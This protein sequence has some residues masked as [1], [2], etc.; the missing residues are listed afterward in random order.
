MLT[1]IGLKEAVEFAAKTEELAQKAY[2]ILA[3]RYAE[4]EDVHQLL[5][6]LAADE[7]AHRRKIRALLPTVP[8]D[9]PEYSSEEGHKYLRGLLM[10]DYLRDDDVLIE[11]IGKMKTLRDAIRWALEFEKDVLLFYYAMRDLLVDSDT[12]NA[13]LLE[14][15]KHV[16]KLV[17]LMEAESSS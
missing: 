15:R 11:K 4:R 5:K 14:E 9:P 17:G 7:G 16:C 2:T 8:E 10:S 3:E 6:T 1:R 12:W 13:I